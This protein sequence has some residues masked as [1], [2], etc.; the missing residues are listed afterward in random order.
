M[1]WGSWRARRGPG[2]A[3]CEEIGRKRVDVPVVQKPPSEVA[4]TSD[5]EGT[6]AWA[7]ASGVEMVEVGAIWGEGRE[8]ETAGGLGGGSR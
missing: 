2:K 1:M 6:L 3:D 8:H 7:P 5:E 4:A